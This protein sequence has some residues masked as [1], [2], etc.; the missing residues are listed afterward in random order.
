MKVENV[1]I[2]KSG[3]RTRESFPTLYTVTNRLNKY[4][5][6][7]QIK[8]LNPYANAEFKILLDHLSLALCDTAI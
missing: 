3:H 8:A 7:I 4:S 1:N 5:H 6:A 2:F